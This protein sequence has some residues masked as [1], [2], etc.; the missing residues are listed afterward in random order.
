MSKKDANQAT[1]SEGAAG[2]AGVDERVILKGSQEFRTDLFKSDVRKFMRNTSFKKGVV[3]ILELDHTHTF[4]SFNSQGKEQEFSSPVGG[5]FHKVI[6][7][8]TDKDGNICLEMGP[9]LQWKQKKRPSGAKKVLTEVKWYN[10]DAEDNSGEQ[11]NIHDRHTH[12]WI[13]QSSEYLSASKVREIQQATQAV[14]AST[15]QDSSRGGNRN[16]DQGG[17]NGDDHG[18]SGLDDVSGD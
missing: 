3:S 9:P 8:Y 17:G 14:V 16:D 4:H 11:S 18:D 6:R 5:H 13:Y 1:K 7:R 12:K 2:R 15:V 10:A